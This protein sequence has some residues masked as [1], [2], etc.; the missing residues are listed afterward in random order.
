MGRRIGKYMIDEKTNAVY[1][2]DT[3]TGTFTNLDLGG[4][5]DVSGASTL[6]STLT[7]AG[8]T[9]LSST[10]AANGHITIGDAKNIVVN[11]STGTKIGTATGQKIAFHNA[12][13]VVQAAHIADIANDAN[14]TAI[15]T[16]VNAILTVLEDKGFTATS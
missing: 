6:D 3:A 7:V 16:A 15:A 13:P 8:A 5:L 4:T 2:Q 11:T 10:L 1:K 12:T 14:G 9:T